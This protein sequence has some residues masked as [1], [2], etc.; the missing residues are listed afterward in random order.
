MALT[1]GTTGVKQKDYRVYVALAS[2]T[3]CRLLSQ[4]I[5]LKHQNSYD[6]HNQLDERGW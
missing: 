3:G 2:T 1:T 5:G 4:T 6:R